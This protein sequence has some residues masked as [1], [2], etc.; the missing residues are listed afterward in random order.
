MRDKT[1]YGNCV[2]FPDPVEDL[3][4]MVESGVKITRRTFLRHVH[5]ESRKQIEKDLGYDGDLHIA[6][7][8]AVSYYKGKLFGRTVVWIYHSSIEYVFS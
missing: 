5:P 7:D 2:N 4:A 3:C 6:N 8:W 1:Y